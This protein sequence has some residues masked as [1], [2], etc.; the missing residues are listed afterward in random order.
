M[1]NR[2]PTYIRTVLEMGIDVLFTD[3]DMVW[4][5]N[6]MAFLPDGYDMHVVEDLHPDNTPPDYEWLPMNMGFVYMSSTE[7]VLELVALWNKKISASPQTPDQVV[8]ND[9]LKERVHRDTLKINVLDNREFPNGW[10]YFNR[11]WNTK[12]PTSTVRVVHNDMVHGYN[13]KVKRFKKRGMWYIKEEH[14]NID[15]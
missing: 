9:I 11:N 14:N 2:R 3:L 6:P 12:F 8:M 15:G 4:L 7:P 1:V 10:N 5:E 13:P